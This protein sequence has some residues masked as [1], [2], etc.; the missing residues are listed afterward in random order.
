M[1]D[2]LSKILGVPLVVVNKAGVHMGAQYVASAKP[3]GYTL[4]NSTIT[5]VIQTVINPTNP[6]KITELPP[7]SVFI[8]CRLSSW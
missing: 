1:S 2:E 5:T 3:D 6:F 7:L 4:F 8:V